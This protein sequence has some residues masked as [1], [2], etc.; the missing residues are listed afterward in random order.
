MGTNFPSDWKKQPEKKTRKGAA[1]YLITGSN[2]IR[3]SE[4][5]DTVCGRGIDATI[6]R[7]Y[8][9]FKTDFLV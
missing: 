8:L 2:C 5:D 7:P 3:H 6:L 4:N 1:R 9:G